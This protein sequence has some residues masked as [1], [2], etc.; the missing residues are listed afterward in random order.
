LKT[1]FTIIGVYG[2]NEDEPVANKDLFYETLQRVVTDLGKNRELV[3]MG[4]FNARTG[5][6]SN[7]YTIGRFGEEESNGNG[8]RLIGLCEQNNLKITNGFFQHKKIY[9][10]T[11]TQKTPKFE[12]SY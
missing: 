7:S 6:S 1:R 2:P 10:F 5:R 4:D 3:L 12:V 8:T 11:W 9:K